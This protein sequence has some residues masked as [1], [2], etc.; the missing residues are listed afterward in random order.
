MN[1][2]TNSTG[3]QAI[4]SV[5]LILDAKTY[6]EAETNCM[7]FYNERFIDVHTEDD[8]FNTVMTIQQELTDQKEAQAYAGITL[9]EAYNLDESQYLTPDEWA[10]QEGLYGGTE[11]LVR[12]AKD[13]WYS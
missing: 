8:F 5:S 1:T 6:A 3:T 10:E 12:T 7:R 4:D 2:T 11:P 9:A 13:S